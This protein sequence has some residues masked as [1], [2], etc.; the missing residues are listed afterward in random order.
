MMS[1]VI[2]SAADTMESS[3][4]DFFDMTSDGFLDFGDLA[5]DVLNQI[6]Q[7]MIKMAII[8][9]LVSG[10]TGM[11]TGMMFAKGD[12]FSGSP[13]LSAHSNTVVSTP[14]PFMFASGGVP[15]SN[16]GIMGEAG[17]EA[18]LPL[19]RTSDGDLGVKAIGGS[20]NVIIN[21][22]NNTSQEIDASM[23]SEMLKTDERGEETKVINIVMK[24]IQT[25]SGFRNALKSSI[26]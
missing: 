19:T 2:K 4:Q 25:N 10:V 26:G 11:A 16:L 13:S 17:H 5:Q 9:P 14:T 6:M 22:E 1:T 23:I 21:I 8:K 15:N 24:N 20:S 7:Q 3:M 18:I 12:S